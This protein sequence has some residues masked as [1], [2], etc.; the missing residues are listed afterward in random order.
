MASSAPTKENAANEPGPLGQKRKLPKSFKLD[1]TKKFGRT[2]TG[3]KVA[4]QHAKE[5]REPGMSTHNSQ[6]KVPRDP[7]N[8]PYFTRLPAELQIEA[9][10]YLLP[11]ELALVRRSSQQLHELVDNFKNDLTKHTITYHLGRLQ[12]SIDNIDA[13]EFPTDAASFLACLRTWTSTRGCFRNPNLS[14]D[15]YNKWFSHLAGGKLMASDGQPEEDFQKWAVLA[16]VSTEFQRR[17]NTF[18]AKKVQFDDQEVDNTFWHAFSNEMSN[19]NCPLDTAERRK[20]YEHIRDARGSQ[21]AINGRWHTAKK[22]RATFPSDKTEKAT[23]GDHAREKRAEKAR[24]E[25]SEPKPEKKAPP[26]EYGRFRLTP[27]LSD[28][29]KKDEVSTLK[30]PVRPADIMCANLGLPNLPAH[31]TFCYYLTDPVFF[32]KLSKSYPD[33]IVLSPLLRA[34]M[35]ECVEI[36]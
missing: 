24:K 10:S 11:K 27:I 9:L 13:V 14:L 16:A 4:R 15:S 20:L 7:P 34:A 17:I 33:A 35:L 32:D 28:L 21:R 30:Y 1:G 31:N 26:A 22:E 23:R 12:A 29:A 36:F 19:F 8:H 3:R 25:F 6:W 5:E 2:A 18:V